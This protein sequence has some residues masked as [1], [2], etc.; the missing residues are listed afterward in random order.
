[1][2]VADAENDEVVRGKPFDPSFA[3]HQ[4]S[5]EAEGYLEH[6]E[7]D[8]QDQER[9]EQEADDTHGRVLSPGFA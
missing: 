4:R 5:G 9:A 2:R 1:M 8:D 3:G 6:A 7:G